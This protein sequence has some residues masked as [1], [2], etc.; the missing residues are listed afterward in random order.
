MQLFESAGNNH[1]YSTYDWI[2]PG[3]ELST[4]WK[5]ISDALTATP[6]SLHPLADNIVTLIIVPRGPVS[7]GPD[8]SPLAANY[9]YDSR[10]ATTPS[11]HS[12]LPPFVEIIM[13]AIDEPSALRLAAAQTDP[14]SAPDL[15]PNFHLGSLFQQVDS[16]DADLSK[17]ETALADN[18]IDYRVFRTTVR[19]DSSRWSK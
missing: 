2:T 6:S 14:T 9:L 10:D 17:L 7:G 8:N 4:R 18:H 1:V 12:Q 15:A 3:K 11:A 13:V 16:L 19:I 5:W